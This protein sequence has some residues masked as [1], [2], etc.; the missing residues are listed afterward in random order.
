MRQLPCV[1]C[2]NKLLQKEPL[3]RLVRL[4]LRSQRQSRL[5]PQ[6]TV[7]HQAQMAT[8]QPT[9]SALLESQIS[10]HLHRFLFA[11]HFQPLTC[12]Q[13]QCTSPWITPF[14]DQAQCSMTGHLGFV[15]AKARRGTG[16]INYVASRRLET[17]SRYIMALSPTFDN[18]LS[19]NT[20]FILFY[21]PSFFGF[22]KFR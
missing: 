2:E 22:R 21:I 13:P 18:F 8:R 14:G 20:T 5:S 19:Y 1:H 10:T 15:E 11:N 7:T 4:L 12:L 17:Q 9:A 6:A 16:P 3:A